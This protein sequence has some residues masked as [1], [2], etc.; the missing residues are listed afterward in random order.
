[1]TQQT[2]CSKSVKEKTLVYKTL[3]GKFNSFS[4]FHTYYNMLP[5][6]HSLGGYFYLMF[7]FLWAR[8]FHIRPVWQLVL[9]LSLSTLS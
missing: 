8:S 6:E 1:M 2:D 5:F 4:V 9:P 7:F 3:V